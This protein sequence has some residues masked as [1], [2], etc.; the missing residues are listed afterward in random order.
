MSKADLLIKPPLLNGAGML[1]FGLDSRVSWAI[2][3]LGAFI[4]NP[5]SLSPRRQSRTTRLIEYP[6]GFL[7]HNGY[8]N[9]GL[10]KVIHDWSDSWSRSPIPVIVSIIPHHSDDILKMLAKLEAIEG[11]AGIEINIPPD[12]DEGELVETARVALSELPLILRIPYELA[13]TLQ[14]GGAAALLETG[15]FAITIQPLRGCL[16]NENDQLVAGRLYGP[17]LFPQTLF[18]TRRLVNLGLPVI[19]GG[20]VYQPYQVEQLLNS[21]AL[22]VQLDSVLWKDPG[23]LSWGKIVSTA[24][25]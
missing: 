21:G 19:A 1:G 20:G 22:A 10:R 24:P 25:K 3:H 16:V 4:T 9:P 13:A 23:L 6:A 8:P 17:A 5:V 12:H 11:V 2:K 18:L 14:V 15:V 7:L